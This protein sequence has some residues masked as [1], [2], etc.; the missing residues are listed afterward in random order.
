MAKPDTETASHPGRCHWAWPMALDPGKDTIAGRKPD[1]RMDQKAEGQSWSNFLG[2]LRVP[3][4]ELWPQEY[5]SLDPCSS[6]FYLG[7]ELCR[8]YFTWF[9]QW[10]RWGSTWNVKVTARTRTQC[11]PIPQQGLFP[12]N[13]V[14]STFCYCGYRRKFFRGDGPEKREITFIK[15]IFSENVHDHCCQRR[16]NCLVIFLLESFQHQVEQGSQ[17]S[18]LWI[19]AS[20]LQRVDEEECLFKGRGESP[21]ARNPR[22]LRLWGNVLREPVP[23]AQLGPIILYQE[24]CSLGPILF[25]ADHSRT[26]VMHWAVKQ[27][28]RDVF[29]TT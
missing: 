28:L 26:T 17:C 21:D 10:P 11:L 23:R 12:L 6:C 14:A 9:S 27:S 5:L 18:S 4:Q 19:W 7:R 2:S 25:S 1:W 13:P 22:A 8:C 29:S 3:E 16:N 20:S 15:A 24:S